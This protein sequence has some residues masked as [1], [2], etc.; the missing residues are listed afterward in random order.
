[1]LLKMIFS[2]QP[3][4]FSLKT[5]SYS[6]VTCASL[7]F[8]ILSQMSVTCLRVKRGC[9][10][11]GGEDPGE[12][13]EKELISGELG[14]GT[15][16]CFRLWSLL[17]SWLMLA[18]TWS[19]HWRKPINVTSITIPVWKKLAYLFEVK[20][21]KILLKS[22]KSWKGVLIRDIEHLS[23][24]YLFVDYCNQNQAKLYIA[25]FLKWFLFCDCE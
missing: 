22:H 7:S 25:L 24:K 12:Y 23:I 10:F 21:K 8:S 20:K 11:R 13:E 14:H 4:S 15:L 6:S 2:H 18:E 16:R 17:H 3:A 5:L 9:S 19:K 1:M